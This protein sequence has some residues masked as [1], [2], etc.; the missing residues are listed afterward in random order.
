MS[1]SEISAASVVPE[2]NS[3]RMRATA[4]R[5][6]GPGA[7]RIDA[8]SSSLRPLMTGAP[9]DTARRSSPSRRP[10]SSIQCSRAACTSVNGRRSSTTIVTRFGSSRTTSARRISGSADTR[11]ATAPP[12]SVHRFVPGAIAAAARMRGTGTRDAP[13][14]ST[15][16][17]AKRGDVV[18]HR[19]PAR[20]VAAP[21]TIR[22]P[23]AARRV[24]RARARARRRAALTRCRA[25]R[26]VRSPR[27]AS[28]P[29][30]RGE[31]SP[32]FTEDADLGL[33]RDP[34]VAVHPLA[35]ELHEAQDVRRASAAAIDDE[36][37]VLGRNLG[38]VDPFA[39]Q[40]G[41]LDQSRGQIARRIL[42]DEAGGG[43]GQRLRG[44]LLLEARADLFRDLGQRPALQPQP[45]ADEHGAGRQVERPVAEGAGWLEL[46]ER[47]VGMQIVDGTH[48]VSDP[49]I[50]PARV[51]GQRAAD[52]GWDTDQALDATEIE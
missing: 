33:E 22:A 34:K 49:A 28:E 2:R 38:A 44:L 45:A 4:A 40:P 37:G 27:S 16:A 43:Q 3:V 7:V 1:I 21:A 31:S 23:T 30:P 14:T 11:A 13:C 17:T 15:A 5:A 42:P 50:G 29:P 24:S 52:G 51:H 8:S 12:S 35:R 10:S 41:L 47:A 20:T 32:L 19:A 39:A 36:V 6:F 18:T 46:A 25:T 26:G 9:G 48:E